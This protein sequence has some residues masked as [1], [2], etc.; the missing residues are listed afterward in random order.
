MVKHG[1][2]VKKTVGITSGEP[3]ALNLTTLQKSRKVKI[4]LKQYVEIQQYLLRIL[5]MSADIISSLDCRIWHSF[6][7]FSYSQMY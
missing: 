5:M 1:S 4:E 6:R 2:K 7:S 3:N